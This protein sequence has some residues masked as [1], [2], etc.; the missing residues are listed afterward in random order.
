MSFI[1]RAHSFPS[2]FLAPG[3]MHK[4]YIALQELWVVA[5]MLHKMAFLLS[6]KVDTVHLDNRTAAAYVIN[7]VPLLFF[8]EE[9]ATF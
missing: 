9:H 5:L 8:P 7:M 4:V 6:C 3:S 1:F 2:P